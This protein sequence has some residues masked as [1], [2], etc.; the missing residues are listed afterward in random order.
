MEI[1]S[2][3]RPVQE[4]EMKQSRSFPAVSLS[5]RPNDDWIG[6]RWL[7]LWH[8]SLRSVWRVFVYQGLSMWKALDDR[9]ILLVRVIRQGT[10]LLFLLL[11]P[12]LLFEFVVTQTI[13]VSF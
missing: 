8:V 7:Y 2:W 3:R 11:L 1:Q 5:Y 10:L 6:T 9:P 13:S 4:R 12:S